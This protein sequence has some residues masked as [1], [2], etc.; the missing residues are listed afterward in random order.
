MHAENCKFFMK[1]SLFRL[2]GCV[3]VTIDC[4]QP[5]LQVGRCHC[6]N[7]EESL[8]RGARYDSLNGPPGDCPITGS[9]LLALGLGMFTDLQPWTF[10]CGWALVLASP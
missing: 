1:S 2:S 9:V 7:P 4:Q 10:L 3:D 5:G 8:D 6:E